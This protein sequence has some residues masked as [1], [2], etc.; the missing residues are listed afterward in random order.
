M[1]LTNEHSQGDRPSVSI[2]IVSYQ[3]YKNHYNGKELVYA[4]GNWSNN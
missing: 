1:S 3:N 4:D 2:S